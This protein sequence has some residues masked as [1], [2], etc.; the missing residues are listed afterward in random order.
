MIFKSGERNF[1]IAKTRVSE[2]EQKILF[3][4]NYSETN[5]IR[6]YSYETHRTYSERGRREVVIF[7]LNVNLILIFAQVVWIELSYSF[8]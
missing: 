8:L 5:Q 6:S 3:R 4:L 7:S 2:S 1:I